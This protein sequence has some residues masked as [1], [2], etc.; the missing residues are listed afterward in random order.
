[1]S[2]KALYKVYGALTDEKIPAIS[3]L[4][5]YVPVTVCMGK[6]MVVI[7]GCIFLAPPWPFVC[8]TYS[9]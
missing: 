6:A 1:M 5:N 9:V 7:S 4:T 3:A 2:V 8:K